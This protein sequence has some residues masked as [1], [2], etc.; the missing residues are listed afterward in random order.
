[1]FAVKVT[2]PQ[3]LSVEFE[4][5]VVETSSGHF[6]W[7]HFEGEMPDAAKWLTQKF[8]IDPLCVDALCDELTRP[9][10]FSGP[11]EELIMT[12]RAPVGEA[13]NEIEYASVR[14]W[15]S[16]QFLVTVSRVEIPMLRNL[17]DKLL[18]QTKKETYS[19]LQLLWR[20]CDGSADQLTHHI[21]SIDEQITDFED[22]WET[23]NHIKKEALHSMRLKMSRVRRY[24]LP[25]LD[26]FQKFAYM[27]D[28]INV[29]KRDVK[30]TKSQWLETVNMLMRNTEVLNENQDRILI[31][32]DTL[33]Q[34]K[35]EV[36]NN[37]MYLLSIVAAFFLPITFITSLLGINVNGIPASEHPWAFAV[38]C[39]VL[40][41]IMA[42]QW[43]LFRRWKWFK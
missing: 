27:T 20:I 17:R 31:L 14:A 32:Q 29:P 33:F 19:P 39:V 5:E 28:T 10:V 2:H 21:V 23:N 25:Q 3:S 16:S 41:S 26:A 24:L 11:N 9:R 12:F 22:E 4:Q 1:M 36:S 30:R 15:A 7:F 43:V 6:V 38:V 35:T 34:Q 13:G 42:I 37:I 18:R 8:Q 40:T